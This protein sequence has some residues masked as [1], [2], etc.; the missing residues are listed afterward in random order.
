MF[1]LE[2]HRHFKAAFKSPKLCMYSDLVDLRNQN[3][4]E[5]FRLL[6]LWDSPQDL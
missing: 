6:S 2:K 1:V 5:Q 4:M 3:F